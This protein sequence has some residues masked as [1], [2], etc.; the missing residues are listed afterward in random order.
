LELSFA[1]RYSFVKAKRRASSSHWR[2]IYNENNN[3]NYLEEIRAEEESLFYF[4]LCYRHWQRQKQTKTL[5]DGCLE[6]H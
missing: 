5:G 3:I 1:K 2:G 4:Q 6:V